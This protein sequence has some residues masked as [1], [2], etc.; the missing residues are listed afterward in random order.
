MPPFLEQEREWPTNVGEYPIRAI[1]ERV[2]IH[3]SS[4]NLIV[5]NTSNMTVSSFH[6]RQ[7][8]EKKTLLQT[9]K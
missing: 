6:N 5:I 9:L 7:K 1:P 4:D 3:P 2:L 8:T